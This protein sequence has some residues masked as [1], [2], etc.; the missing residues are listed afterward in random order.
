MGGMAPVA[1]I[2]IGF[3]FI[4]LAILQK[5][6]GFGQF[7]DGASWMIVL[8]GSFAATLISFA[9]QNIVHSFRCLVQVFRPREYPYSDTVVKLYRIASAARTGSVTGIDTEAEAIEDT[10]FRNAVERSTATADHD[11]LRDLLDIQMRALRKEH[12]ENQEVFRRMGAYA[13][14]FGM[15]GTLIGLIIMLGSVEGGDVSEISQA[16]ST[17]LVTTFI[18]LIASNLLFMPIAA[19]IGEQSE[20]EAAYYECVVEGVIAALGGVAPSRVFDRVTAF[21][22]PS[23]LEE[24]EQAVAAVR[25][26]G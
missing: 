3:G 17:A 10:F 16:M 25:S 19:K 1:G 9:P 13:P 11:E 2:V 7:T 24:V 8:G 21:V 20:R 23:E 5:D 15:I 18:G 12:H 4:A 22:P 14:A 6:A 26:G